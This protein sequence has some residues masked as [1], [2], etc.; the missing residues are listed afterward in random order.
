MKP[1][2]IIDHWLE[3]LHVALTTDPPSAFELFLQ[4]L[5]T[6]YVEDDLPTALRLLATQD[7]KAYL[8]ESMPHQLA[9][10]WFLYG[11]IYERK[12]DYSQA[13][14]AYQTCL[15]YLQN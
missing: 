10:Y 14:M 13:V 12:G 11:R 4:E 8:W 9:Q 15:G 7:W 3:R 6:A 2:W 5:L 1:R